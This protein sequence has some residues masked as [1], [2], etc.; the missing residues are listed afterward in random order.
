[1]LVVE[2]KKETPQ[3]NSLKKNQR[4]LPEAEYMQKVRKQE[5]PNLVAQAHKPCT[6]SLRQE[7]RNLIS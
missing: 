7:D 4:S 1:M 2:K 3:Q 5:K 6:G